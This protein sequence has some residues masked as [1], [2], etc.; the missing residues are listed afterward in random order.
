MKTLNKIKILLVSAMIAK[1]QENGD[2]IVTKVYMSG[3]LSLLT[4]F[5]ILPTNS[6]WQGSEELQGLLL[7]SNRPLTL[8]GDTLLQIVDESQGQHSHTLCSTSLLPNS[9]CLGV[10]K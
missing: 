2:E 1:S 3:T 9:P 5:S 8:L 10:L 6:Q 4:S 7:Q